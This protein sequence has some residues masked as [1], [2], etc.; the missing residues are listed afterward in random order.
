MKSAHLIPFAAALAFLAVAP[1]VAHHSF[2]LE[3]DGTMPVTITGTVTKTGW[4]NPHMWFCLATTDETGAV[5]RWQFEN[6]PPNALRRR[7]LTAEELKQGTRITVEG[8]LA[9][10]P[11]QNGVNTAA[12][13]AITLPGGRR[14]S[15]QDSRGW[16]GT[17]TFFDPSTSRCNQPP[18]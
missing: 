9:R 15:T 10:Q 14:V 5:A 12:A 17:T 8:F 6:A 7:G 18:E 11:V 16:S 2:D 4:T 3:F 13:A 1:A